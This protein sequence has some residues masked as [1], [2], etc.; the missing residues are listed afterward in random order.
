MDRIRVFRETTVRTECDACGARFDLLKGGA[1]PTC[2]NIYC[3]THL[4]GSLV[5][6]LI[7]DVTGRVECVYCRAGV[8]PPVGAGS[9]GNAGRA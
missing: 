8:T 1:C 6:R 9:A 5:R 3:G 7:A 2:R 4:H